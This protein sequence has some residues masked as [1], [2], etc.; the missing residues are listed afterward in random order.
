L[1]QSAGATGPTGPTGP[2]S[3]SYISQASL[4]T[5]QSVSATTDTVVQYVDDLDP[6]NWWDS[7]NYRFQPTING[8]YLINATVWL[9]TASTGSTGQTNLQI[10]TN[11]STQKAIVQQPVNT[12]AGSGNSLAIS[13][14]LQL[15]GSTDYVQITF[16]TSATAGQTLQASSG[17][18]SWFYTALQ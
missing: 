7:A 4:S 1:A 10:R 16:Y 2:A 5:D 14:I 8:Y 9:T 3:T 6:N 15:N 11:G 17:N 13:K 12:T 18:G